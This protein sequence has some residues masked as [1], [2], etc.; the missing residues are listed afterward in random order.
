MESIFLSVAIV[1]VVK[2][3]DLLKDHN[4]SSALKIVL[5]AVVGG[6]VGA[7]HIQGLDI[8]SGIQAGL[9]ASGL[10]TTTKF[11]SQG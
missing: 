7:F 9:F 4:Y 5:A 11:I 10:V 3:V 6:A 2:L 1:A 8:V